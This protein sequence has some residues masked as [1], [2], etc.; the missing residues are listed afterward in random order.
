[1]YEQ[2]PC[3]LRR[4]FYIRLSVWWVFQRVV[5]GHFQDPQVHFGANWLMWKFSF[6]FIEDSITVNDVRWKKNSW[7]KKTMFV[8]FFFI[9]N[10]KLCW[11]VVFSLIFVEW[12]FTGLKTGRSIKNAFND[13]VSW[14][15]CRKL[16]IKTI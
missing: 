4:F 14:F 11:C 16:Y 5:C 10:W 3:N 7:M 2:L 15:S 1:M 6:C 9:W 13:Y 12:H 8:C